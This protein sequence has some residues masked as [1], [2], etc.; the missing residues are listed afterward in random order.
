MC[1][2][3]LESIKPTDSDY[4]TNTHPLPNKSPRHASFSEEMDYILYH[5]C[6]CLTS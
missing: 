2:V 4:I 5:C 1:K 6:I 3:F